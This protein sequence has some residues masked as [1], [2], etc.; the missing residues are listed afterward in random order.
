MFLE[1]LMAAPVSAV[2]S[3]PTGFSATTASSSQ[4]NLS[5][6]NASGGLQTEVYRNGTLRTTVS[7]GVT[8]FADTTI[9]P[10]VEYSY[11]I[12]HKSGTNFSVFT[13]TLIRSGSP[14]A[15][16][17]VVLS[18][19]TDDVTVQWS[20]TS[21][22]ATAVRVYRNGVNVSGDLSASALSYVDNNVPNGT[23]TYTVRN[24]NGVAES[25]DSP[26]NEITVSYNPPLSDPSSF[27]ANPTHS[28]RVALSWV[29][30]D[31]T[32]QTEIYRGTS[33]DPTTLIAT[34][35]AGV[36]TYNDDARTQGTQYYYRIRH[37]KG[38]SLSGYVS[39]DA[40]TPVTTLSLINLFADEEN[41]EIILAF[42]VNNPPVTPQVTHGDWSDTLGE[43]SVAGPVTV[44]SSPHVVVAYD[45]IVQLHTGDDVTGTLEYLRVRDGAGNLLHELTSIT[46]DFSTSPEA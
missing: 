30:G 33:P 35:S 23:Y 36:T 31:A 25:A 2:I 18:S 44:P 22:T 32:A 16:G 38:A 14:L 41:E 34:R 40:T 20:N 12:R 28:D 9:S 11:K 46:V 27:V 10:G 42:D 15:P 1:L 19:V 3:P 6:T 7:A 24:W 39:D 43:E 37:V 45:N 5:W 8:S 26:S 13:A 29:Y 4:I 21:Q 17:P